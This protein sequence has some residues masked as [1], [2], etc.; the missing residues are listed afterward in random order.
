LE[1]P[2][3]DF[4][5]NSFIGFSYYSRLSG[6]EDEPFGI[7]MLLKYKRFRAQ[8]YLESFFRDTHE[9]YYDS[10]HD[11]EVN[12]RKKNSFKMI[13]DYGFRVHPAFGLNPGLVLDISG[14]DYSETGYGQ[15]PVYVDERSLYDQTYF[16]LSPKVSL[17]IKQFN[18][19]TVD[20]MSQLNLFMPALYQKILEGTGNREWLKYGFMVNYYL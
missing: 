19:L 3:Y 4:S 10:D 20:I 5:D 8:L 9:Y 16:A 11:E 18:R 12:V 13:L 15:S 1:D 6:Y 17:E 14:I 7:G 2:K